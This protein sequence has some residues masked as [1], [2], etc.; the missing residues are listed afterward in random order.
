MRFTV[1]WQ[2]LDELLERLRR[3]SPDMRH[4]VN[5][6]VTGASQLVAT[7]ARANMARMFKGPVAEIEVR[8]T[9]SGDDVTGEVTAGGT[10]YARIH[11]YGGVI[12]VPDIFPKYAQALH[13]LGNL[14]AQQ[15]PTIFESKL[16][17]HGERAVGDVFAMSAQA[18]DVRI[19]ERSYLRA[20][21][22]QREAE[23]Q[24]VFE[25]IGDG[26]AQAA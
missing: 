11:E 21:L 4:R 1:E 19:P 7:Q 3:A 26:L 14:L 8:V 20:A 12:H 22:H 23:I 13:W 2:G 5:L 17:F 15:N 9:R 18:H 10:V 24:T 25:H 6:A 16:G